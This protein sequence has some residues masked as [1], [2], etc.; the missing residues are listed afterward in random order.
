[1]NTIAG[2]LKTVGQIGSAALSLAGGMGSLG[3]TAGTKVS[4]G[5]AGDSITF[6]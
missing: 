1:M 4:G 5:I 3:E 2:G 6:A